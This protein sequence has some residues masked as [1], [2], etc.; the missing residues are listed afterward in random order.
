MLDY[1]VKN[2]DHILTE[3]KVYQIRFQENLVTDMCMLEFLTGMLDMEVE[4]WAVL[5]SSLFCGTICFFSG[6]QCGTI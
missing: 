1:A 3:W 6:N 5:L 2:Q 4:G